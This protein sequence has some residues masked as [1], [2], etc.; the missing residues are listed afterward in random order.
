MIEKKR[1]ANISQ[2]KTI[3]KGDLDNLKEMRCE[4]DGK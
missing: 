1:Q 2:G 4:K 3:H